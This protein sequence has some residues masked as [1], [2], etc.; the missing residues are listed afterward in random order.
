MKS[1]I[2]TLVIAVLVALAT[3]STPLNATET[4]P[5]EKG[6]FF[7]SQAACVATWNSEGEFRFYQPDPRHLKTLPASTKGLPRAGCALEDVRENKGKSPSWVILAPNVPATF[8]VNGTPVVDGRCH[9]KIHE[10]VWLPLLRG[11]PGTNGINGTNGHDGYTP[12]KG[13]DYFDG[14]N[15]ENFVPGGKYHGWCGI[16]TDLGCT[17]LAVGAGGIIYVATR[18]KGDDGVSPDADTGGAFLRAGAGITP[19]IGVVPPSHGRGGGGFIG[20]SIGW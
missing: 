13:K 3:M 6:M 15:G 2:S 4:E 17:A 5:L 7:G 19:R 14:K 10:F 9:N 16:W 12:V 8:D 1:F 11:L 20:A 18:D